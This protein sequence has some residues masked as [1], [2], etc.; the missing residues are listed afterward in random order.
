V[1]PATI[2]KDGVLEDGLYAGARATLAQRNEKA[3]QTLESS[4]LVMILSLVVGVLL[5]L[6]GLLWV[7]RRITHPVRRLMSQIRRQGEG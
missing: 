1:T 3:A 4:K 7:R 6:G 5:G 2:A